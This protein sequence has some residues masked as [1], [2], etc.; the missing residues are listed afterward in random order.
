[1]FGTSGGE[2]GAV[3]GAVAAVQSGA[4]ADPGDGPESGAGQ[5]TGA[6]SDCGTSWRSGLGCGI[7]VL[8]VLALVVVG[9]IAGMLVHRHASS[10]TSATML[11][12]QLDAL[13]AAQQAVPAD[14]GGVA[15]LLAGL[16]LPGGTST[17]S[18]FRPGDTVIAIGVTGDCVFVDVHQRRLD[19]WPAPELSPCTASLAY[20]TVLLQRRAAS[21]SADP[22]VNRPPR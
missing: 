2:G 11:A 13:P 19:A 4:G 5:G 9:Q 10:R 3:A 8:S 20:R 7:T 17:D 6:G 18:E 14:G 1:M 22:A 21:S 16:G 15:S 12:E